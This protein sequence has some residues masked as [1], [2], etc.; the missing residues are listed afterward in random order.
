MKKAMEM[1]LNWIFILIAGAIILAFFMGLFSW[2]K[3]KKNVELADESLQTIKAT[4]AS[5]QASSHTAKM[6]EIPNVPLQ[7]F[8]DPNTC[9]DYGCMSSIVFKDLGPKIETEVDVFYGPEEMQ[10]SK[11]LTW[12]VPW[13][14]PY[15]VTDFLYISNPGIRYV[16]VY[17]DDD[18]AS[19][20]LAL[21]VDSL[22]SD[23]KFITKQIIE[24]A[25]ISLIEDSG[26]YLVKFILFYS[27][28]AAI[29]VHESLADSKNWDI[30]RIDGDES[31]GLVT[32]MYER[33]TNKPTAT[34]YP[35]LGLPMLLGSI[36]S[37]KPSSY[38]CNSL[39]AMKRLE[40]VNHVYMARTESLFKAYESG[41]D[42]KFYYDPGT[43]A[44]FKAINDSVYGKR[45]LRDIDWA[46][47]GGAMIQLESVNDKVLYKDCPR[48]Y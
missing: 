16:L 48:L 25:R 45:L 39:K 5:A 21:D 34:P 15:K 33:G 13:E 11:L 40:L 28:P 29:T 14:Q 23:N 10:N 9:G 41:N 32:F 47:I 19:K 42:C 7:F 44:Q 30:I 31:G 36:F 18:L 1:Q 20:R 38:E 43:I 2:Y 3:A 26:D 24:S 6:I 35:Y 46:Q 4:L 8:C 37:E 22:L 12:T 17:S 27:P